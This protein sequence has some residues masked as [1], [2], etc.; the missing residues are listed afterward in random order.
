MHTNFGEMHEETVPMSMSHLFPWTLSTNSGSA[1][2]DQVILEMFG[3]PFSGLDMDGY[4]MTV[5]G[6][7]QMAGTSPASS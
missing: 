4:G 7:W 2:F 5:V 6:C 3:S 1:L